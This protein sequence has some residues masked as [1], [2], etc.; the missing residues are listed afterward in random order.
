MKKIII[1]F[2]FIFLSLSLHAQYMGEYTEGDN[3]YGVCL[4]VNNLLGWEINQYFHQYIE[5]GVEDDLILFRVNQSR[6]YIS[7]NSSANLSS[8]STTA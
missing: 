8:S 2:G 4:D 5:K 3:E 7:R 6:S 1:L